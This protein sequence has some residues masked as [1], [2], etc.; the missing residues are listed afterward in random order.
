MKILLVYP[1]YPNTYWSFSGVL[2]FIDKKAVFPPLG[3]LTIAA[4]VPPEWEK[5]LV[6]VNVAPIKDEDI[7]WADMIF[8]SAMIVQKDDAISIIQRCKK[9]GKRIV[10][11]DHFLQCFILFLSP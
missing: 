6:D 1:K 8:I 11:A 10:L 9:F 4:M 2:K 3:L 7:L 5:K